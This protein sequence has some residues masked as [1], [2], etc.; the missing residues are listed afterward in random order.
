LEIFENDAL[1]ER[2]IFRFNADVSFKVDS[3]PRLEKENQGFSEERGRVK[4]A[5]LNIVRRCSL[6]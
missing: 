2:D 1:Q 6:S 3:S 5:F 4:R